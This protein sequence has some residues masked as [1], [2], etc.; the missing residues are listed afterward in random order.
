[1]LK[2]QNNELHL[3]TLTALKELSTAGDYISQRLIK[4]YNTKVPILFSTKEKLMYGKSGDLIN[5]SPRIEVGIGSPYKLSSDRNFTIAL[6]TLFHEN[7]H[8]DQILSGYTEKAYEKTEDKQYMAISHLSTHNNDTYYRINY[9]KN[10]CEIMAE[11]YGIVNAYMYLY[12]NFNNVNC[13]DIL[14]DYVNFRINIKDANYFIQH[15][16]NT[17]K[18]ES[19]TDVKTAFE[20]AFEESKTE[21][22]LYLSSSVDV[23]HDE[24]ATL[25][26][27]DNLFWDDVSHKFLPTLNGIDYDKKMACLVLYLHPE[28]KGKIA[29]LDDIDFSFE[30]NFHL[31]TPG[32]HEYNIYYSM[33]RY[34]ND[35]NYR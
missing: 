35:I 27:T 19:L 9:S 30:S 12:K 7:R 32:S 25:L 22:R 33:T 16:Q 3:N 34:D 13:E 31:P 28:Y 5:M 15:P 26:K 20:N 24:V 11:Y 21:K 8:V 29:I 17:N 4:K 2:K 23:K 6:V 14:L 10:P 1:M 18:Y